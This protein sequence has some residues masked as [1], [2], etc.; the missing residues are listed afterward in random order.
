M[1]FIEYA[2]NG[3]IPA[4][5]EMLIYWIF[6]NGF[7]EKKENSWK[8]IARIAILPISLIVFGYFNIPSSFKLIWMLFIGGAITFFTFQ[9]SIKN[10]IIYQFIWILLSVVGD[11][12]SV[13]VLFLGNENVDMDKLI[14]NTNL[15]IQGVILS[16]TIN[17]LLVSVLVK[18]RGK[19]STRYSLSEMFIMILQGV[20]GIACLSMV[21]E[22]TYYRL[23]TYKVVSIY[24]L[25]LSLLV[26]S[27]YII[28]YQ[29]FENY[30]K[31]KN[32]EREALKIQFYNKGQFEYFSALEEENINVR[33]MHHDI[34]N[35]LLAIKG[36]NNE[37]P[38]L[39]QAYIQEC[40]EAV[41]GFSQFY[42][43]GSS[44][45]DIILYEKCKTARM[46]HINTKVMIQKDSLNHIEMLDLC[47][48]LTNGID[49]AIEACKLYEGDR[50]IQVKSVK[51]EASLIL[52]I[53][54]NY[55]V[56]P[57]ENE[58]GG[59]ITRKKSKGEHGVGMQSIKMAAQKYNG[60][61]KI[62]IDQ[63]SKEFLLIIMIPNVA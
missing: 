3:S 45:A 26:F 46:S 31:K 30:I 6:F 27:A 37:N 42:D 53:K 9:T 11:A 43:T 51:N 52:T 62:D 21:L 48:I 2:L 36:L 50:L 41:E 38:E 56:E 61:V 54:N 29:I 15:Y 49:N 13:G 40:L 23:S 25:V 16:K 12:I 32:I 8:N 22:F 47:T 10:I 58:K 57:I 1:D 63:N 7:F 14:N 55:D 18:R 20:S 34:K 28:F 5:V 33:K 39:A 44:L 24:L 60:N 17:L 19:V 35:H 59:F 4:L